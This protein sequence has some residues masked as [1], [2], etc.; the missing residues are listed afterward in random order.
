[1]SFSTTTDDAVTKAQLLHL[2]S[3]RYNLIQL[4]GYLRT[5]EHAETND[6]GW[7]VWN[8]WINSL[9]VA[10]GLLDEKIKETEKGSA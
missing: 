3:Q 10:I 5:K 8:D 6:R 2:K 9:K 7:M 1:M 4:Q